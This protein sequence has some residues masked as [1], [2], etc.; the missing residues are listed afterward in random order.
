[1]T[2]AEMV[3]QALRCTPDMAELRLHDLE[4]ERALDALYRPRRVPCPPAPGGG[5]FIPFTREENYDVN[6]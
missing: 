2:D 1:M 4:Q 5:D 6:D 3:Q